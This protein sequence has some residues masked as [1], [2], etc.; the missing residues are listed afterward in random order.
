M[1]NDYRE[2]DFSEYC[3]KCKHVKKNEDESPC[4][5]CLDNPINLYSEKPVKWEGEEK[6][7]YLKY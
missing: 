3:H 1:D 5:E 4:D 6:W 2:V 7:Y